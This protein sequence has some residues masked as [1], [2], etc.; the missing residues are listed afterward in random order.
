M[1]GA[2]EVSMPEADE[3]HFFYQKWYD[4][5]H[6]RFVDPP[7]DALPKDYEGMA[8]PDFCPSCCRCEEQ[9]KVSSFSRIT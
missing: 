8:C 9:E 6:A 5:D 2:E 7:G 1:L 4:S 3:E